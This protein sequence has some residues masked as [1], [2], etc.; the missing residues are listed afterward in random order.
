MGIGTL[1]FILAVRFTDLLVLRAIQGLGVALTVPASMALMASASN[2]KTRG[3]SMGVYSTSRMTGFAL[4]PLIG[5]F[6]Y[7]RF[8][9]DIS[10][11]TGAGLIAVALILVQIMI[12]EIARKAPIGS[13]R[14]IRII[15]RRLLS[16][17]IF[18]AGLASF[19]MAGAFSMMTPLEVQFNARLHET[20][21][22]FG[23]AF[24]ALM[25]SRLV[26]Q[27]PVG[28]LSDHFGRKPFIIGGLV[29]MALSTAVLG[30]AGSTMELIWIRVI[31]GIG[32]AGIAAPAFALAAD[33][34][35]QG[36]EARQMSIITMGFGLGI[37][38]GPLI[39]GLLAKTSFDLPF[40]VFG[41]LL[42]LSAW[43]IY[44]LVPETIRQNPE[45]T[46]PAN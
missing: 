38:A 8:G 35:K 27:I 41:A 32:A 4:G 19:M 2:P 9:F 22:E 17:G 42:M 26:I 15:D 31:Q 37:A 14:R 25:V 24:S 7:D 3:G 11:Y 1:G 33:L 46:G 36:G 6:L 20:A 23:I 16:A 45:R 29:L 13:T 39:A 12:K 43:V 40:L 30:K 18:G 10:F 5:G 21:L 28:R 34:T 44:R